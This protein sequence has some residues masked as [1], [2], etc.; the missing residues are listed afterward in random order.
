MSKLLSALLGQVSIDE[1]L[2][3]ESIQLAGCERGARS[4]LVFC[5]VQSRRRF[6]LSSLSAPR[7]CKKEVLKR[8]FVQI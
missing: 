6:P 1:E 3:L 4:F 5:V 2:L 8:E 7:P